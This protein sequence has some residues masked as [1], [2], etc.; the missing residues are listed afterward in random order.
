MSD[1]LG[2][3]F[4]L[5]G[6]NNAAPSMPALPLYAATQ[7]DSEARIAQFRNRPDIRQQIEHFTSRMA[8]IETPEELMK[9]RR[10]MEFLLTSFSLEDEMKYPGRIRK[11]LTED[12]DKKDALVNR[13]IDP[14]F[15]E[16]AELT[17]FATRGLERLNLPG[18][19]DEL[20]DRFVTNAFEK[21]MGEQNPAL[22]SALF[23]KRQAGKVENAFN[24]LGDRVL[25]EVTLTTL[26]LPPQIAMQTVERQKI[27]VDKRL[28]VKRLQ[29]PQFLDQFIR[30][31]LILSD[32]NAREQAFQQGGGAGGGLSQ[33]L[34]APQNMTGNAPQGINLL[35]ILT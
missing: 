14:R 13:L 15:K 29:D 31:Y 30:R 35:N 11:V 22:R 34:P 25:R 18:V 27:E 33:L 26:G 16:I 20:V 32:N 21:S 7:R 28:D 6:G 3:A 4:G 9:D 19:V 2:I 5:G 10:L 23:F 17:R 8:K 1:L 24:L 12:P